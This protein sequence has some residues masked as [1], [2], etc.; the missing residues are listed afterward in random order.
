M[1]ARSNRGLL[2]CL[3]PPCSPDAQWNELF[4]C[5]LCAFMIVRLG[6][7]A[8]SIRMSAL[9]TCNNSFTCRTNAGAMRAKQQERWF[10]H[11][12][13]SLALT[14]LQMQINWSSMHRFLYFNRFNIMG[15][16]PLNILKLYWIQGYHHGFNKLPQ[17]HYY[18]LTDHY[19]CLKV[20]TEHNTWRSC[21]ESGRNKTGQKQYLKKTPSMVCLW[22]LMLGLK[23]SGYS[24]FCLFVLFWCELLNCIMYCYVCDQK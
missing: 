11:I 19:F 13:P 9:V 14:G 12:Q 5:S 8:Q 1:L 20:L 18:H 17:P 15:L 16:L 24:F 7:H 10:P 3:L 4:N 21:I 23:A 6:P 22:N 2:L